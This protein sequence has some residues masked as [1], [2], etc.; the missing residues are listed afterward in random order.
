MKKNKMLSVN[1]STGKIDRHSIEKE[2]IKFNEERKTWIIK[3]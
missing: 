1:L 2:S 3:K